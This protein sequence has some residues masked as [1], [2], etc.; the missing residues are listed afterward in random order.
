MVLLFRLGV[1][2]YALSTS[3]V[4]EVLPAFPLRPQP[5][6]PPYIAG[7]LPHADQP[8]PVLDLCRL[9]LGR[10]A[11]D[12][13]AS[14]IIVVRYGAGPLGLLAEEVLELAPIADQDFQATG[15]RLPEARFLGPIALYQGQSVQRIELDDILDASL[16]SLLY[17]D[18]VPGGT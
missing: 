16:R 3:L 11:Q 7:I 13:M 8:F 15:L 12:C 5:L 14:R 4:R 18:T 1:E 6:A 10:P 9:C 2:R 17:P